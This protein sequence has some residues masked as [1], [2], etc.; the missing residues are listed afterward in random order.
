MKAQ[1]T[2]LILFIPLCIAFYLMMKDAD[3][4]LRK[5]KYEKLKDEKSNFLSSVGQIPLNS[6]D[7]VFCQNGKLVYFDNLKTRTTNPYN[8]RVISF[9]VTSV[10]IDEK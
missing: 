1:P 3:T 9:N 2:W 10:T 4:G 5:W 8:G 6:I 7:Q